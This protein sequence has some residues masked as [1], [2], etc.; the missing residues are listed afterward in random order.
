M[1]IIIQLLMLILCWA[2]CLK[3]SHSPHWFR[4]LYAIGLGLFVYLTSDFASRQTR[5][6]LTQYI[7]LDSL[8][9]YVTILV[10]V[11][12]MLLSA[13]CFRIMHTEDET[14]INTTLWSK[15][16]GK[17]LYFYPPMLI[18][19]ILLYVHTNLLFMWTGA[20][21]MLL[22]VVLAIVVILC[23]IFLPELISLFFPER[24]FRLELLCLST[25]I[26]F[27]LVI[28]TTMDT[29]LIYKAPEYSFPIKGF[30]LVLTLL[31]VCF[32]I[33]YLMSNVKYQ[34]FKKK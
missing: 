25:F 9:E 8:R 2:T 30:G 26:L 4:F 11:E 20:D 10:V 19:P 1:E 21:F 16:W 33:G 3:L 29:R 7:Q 14:S 28:V 5:N 22:S 23:F 12:T 13:F 6:S 24:V 15:V 27:L 31:M 17:F 34:I 32:I 18:L